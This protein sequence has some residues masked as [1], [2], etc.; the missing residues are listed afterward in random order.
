[1]LVG[2]MSI[3]LEGLLQLL[4]LLLPSSRAAMLLTLPVLSVSTPPFTSF[5]S[6]FPFSGWRAGLLLTELILFGGGGGGPLRLDL[7]ANEWLRLIL[8]WAPEVVVCPRP[9]LR[10]RVA[11][12]G[13]TA[14]DAELLCRF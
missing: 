13:I 2:G 5:S 9:G 12:E 6:A 8:R 1:M 3:L 4:L 11:Y 10:D 14:E 7:T